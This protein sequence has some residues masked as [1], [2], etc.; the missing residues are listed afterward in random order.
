MIVEI[1]ALNPS[2]GS[3]RL[4]EKWELV[5]GVAYPLA[6]TDEIEVPLYP[7]LGGVTPHDG[8]VYL[9]RLVAVIENSSYL[10]AVVSTDRDDV[11]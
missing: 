8:E 3:R 2:G 9:E 7:S 10:D 6:M 1:Y 4:A 11:M 5:D